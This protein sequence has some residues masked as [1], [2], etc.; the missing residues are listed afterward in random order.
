MQYVF[1]NRSINEKITAYELKH[2][3]RRAPL[4]LEKK[5]SKILS[6][7]LT[8]EDTSYHYNKFRMKYL[9]EVMPKLTTLIGKYFLFDATNETNVHKTTA[10]SYTHLTLPTKRIV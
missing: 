9:S 2:S 6:K 7:F 3:F 8:G 4:S 5:L 1:G 10:V